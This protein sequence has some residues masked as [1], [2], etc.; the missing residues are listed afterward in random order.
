MAHGRAEGAVGIEARPVDRDGHIFR[1]TN[2][3]NAA[4]LSRLSTTSPEHYLASPRL[5]SVPHHRSGFA[6]ADLYHLT[7]KLR[8]D[9]TQAFLFLLSF[10]VG[11]AGPIRTQPHLYWE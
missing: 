9:Y 7:I 1:R 11:D 8:R 2:A 3:L 10:M 6:R 5:A 4:T